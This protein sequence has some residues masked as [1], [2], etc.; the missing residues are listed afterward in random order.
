MF[1]VVVL[2]CQLGQA[3][4]ECIPQTAVDVVRL[5]TVSNNWLCISQS[6]F[7]LAKT[8]FAD[9]THYTKTICERDK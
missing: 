5:G 2:I 4:R 8:D 3:P 6:Q 9:A 1:T 7:S